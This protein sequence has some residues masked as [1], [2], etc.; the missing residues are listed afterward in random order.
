MPN[1]LQVATECDRRYAWVL[2]I[3]VRRIAERQRGSHVTH[4]CQNGAFRASSRRGPPLTF[5]S[6]TGCR[7]RLITR[8]WL[9]TLFLQIFFRRSLSRHSDLLRFPA[10]TASSAAENETRSAL[11]GTANPIGLPQPSAA[12][13]S[14]R[15]LA[16]SASFAIIVWVWTSQAR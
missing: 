15:E 16:H 12:C 13:E 8:T 14:L 4:V 7:G 10:T 3:R 11:E 1:W 5:L 6:R 9:I 2:S